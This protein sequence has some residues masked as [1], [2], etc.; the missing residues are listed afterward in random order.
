MARRKLFVLAGPA[1]L[2]LSFLFVFTSCNFEKMLDSLSKTGVNVFTGSSSVDKNVDSA[3]QVIGT[4][5]GDFDENLSD[6]AENVSDAVENYDQHKDLAKATGDILGTV[7]IDTDTYLD[8]L[9]EVSKASLT[10]EGTKKFAESILSSTITLEKSKEAVTKALEGMKECLNKENDGLSSDYK[11]LAYDIIDSLI[12]QN[13]GVEYTVPYSDVLIVSLMATA[14]CDLVQ[15]LKNSEESGESLKDMLVND[16]DLISEVLG[17]VQIAT[18][19]SKGANM[20][21]KEPSRVV[22]AIAGVNDLIDKIFK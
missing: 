5:I 8:I 6:I 2:F 13:N 15:T 9:A 12:E 20:L 11:D 17:V 7:R 21:G 3:V 4:A 10:E 1:L 22:S 19:I 16:S 14:A 18:V